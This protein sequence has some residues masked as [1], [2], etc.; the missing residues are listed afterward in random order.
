MSEWTESA[1]TELE[2]YL[3][4]AGAAAGRSADATEVIDDLRNHVHEEIAAAGI[5]IVTE[6]DVRR[7]T[8]R[9][10]L[11]EE[12]AEEPVHRPAPPATAPPVE[13]R[14][15][16]GVGLAFLFFFGILLPAATLAIELFTAMC[17]ATFF[18]PVPTVPHAVL[19]AL[20]PITNLLV[21]RALR[22]GNLASRDWLGWANGIA[23]GIGI[24]YSLLFLPITPLGAIAIV[25]L[26]WGLLPL[27]PL[28]GLVSTVFLR[29]RL[30]SAG[31]RANTSLPGFWRGIAI[32]LIATAVLNSPVWITRAC[33]QWA[34]SE[35]EV[36]Q[37]RGLAWLR[38]VGQE[39]TMLRACYGRS[40]GAAEFD[41][42]EWM[43]SGGPRVSPDQA[44]LLYYRV[45]GHAFNAVPAPKLRSARGGVF[46]DL[47]E[48]TW[49]EDHGGEKVGGR[50]KG[51]T[52]HSSR[53][54]AVVENDAALAYCE[55]I[56]E[57][58]N[59][60]F[61]EREARGQIQLPPGAVVSRL[62]L[63]VN[64]EEREAAFAG[65]SQV[66]KAYQEVAIRQRRDPVLVNTCGPDRIL[67]QCFPVPR[68]GGIMKL[69]IGMTVPLAL[70]DAG[71]GLFRL[72][73]F[74]ER[75]FSIRETLRHSVWLK[76]NSG[77]L[78][79]A[80]LTE[81]NGANSVQGLLRDRDLAGT[82]SVVRVMRNVAALSA[83]A[84]D[85]RATGKPGFVVQTL[86]RRNQARPERVILVLDR[87]PAMAEI[88]AHDAATLAALI[89]NSAGGLVVAGDG[90][91]QW[92]LRPGEHNGVGLDQIARQIRGVR[93]NGG[94]DNVPALLAAWDEA[95]KASNAVVLWV[96]GPQPVELASAEPLLQRLERNGS[97][98]DILSFQTERGPNYVLE[99]LD[100]RTHV[101]SV[102]RFDEA[103]EDLRRLAVSWNP[104]GGG[105][106]RIL[107]RR[108]ARP[109]T[110]NI[111]EAS[112]HL[113]RLW[114]R[115]EL[116][117]LR[118]AHRE[119]EAIPLA[120]LYQLVTP[121]S[122]AVVLETDQQYRDH[123]LTPSDSQTVP[124]IPEPTG[125]ALLLV[126]A[127]VLWLAKRRNTGTRTACRA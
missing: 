125:T 112:D 3:K 40:R 45:T 32:G 92:L 41:P 10:G 7:I 100:G 23:I 29:A 116:L 83:V 26:G 49:D 9:L 17:A 28:L 114:I 35:D 107:E 16:K 61:T 73:A 94:F 25:F 68:D 95:A 103:G 50:I 19:V 118:K 82:R 18:D 117:R 110:G 119:T 55:W 48:W 123:N 47:N 67:M 65:R 6:E 115:D 57:F 93:C 14:S 69:R 8:N 102:A 27:S 53:L 4:R 89:T 85:P 126:A 51:L 81:T 31:A 111:I 38:V 113:V 21:W 22:S 15:G 127:V 5:K 42:V 98:T 20:V 59:D 80:A 13:D 122:G 109:D 120:T 79:C 52:L 90:D 86:Q 84:A 75:N 71:H 104:E 99:K 70:D 46:A 62:T 11:P 34:V 60:S 88:L 54:D 72:P 64:G 91:A 66:R 30:R 39:E 101:R 106:T 105:W 74:I 12:N 43:L 37:T 56:M 87:S 36:V 44:R 1:K 97:A 24:F 121:I 108:T 63:W 78:A 33:L 2:Q 124:A 96:H 76:S 58:K 77:Q